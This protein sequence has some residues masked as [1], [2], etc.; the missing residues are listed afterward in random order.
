MFTVHASDS[1]PSFPGTDH[2]H[3]APP[4]G[5]PQSSQAPD[6]TPV[7]QQQL[8]TLARARLRRSGDATFLDTT[9]LVHEACMHLQHAGA[10]GFGDRPD[11]LLQASQLLR[12]VVVGAV[13]SH[14]AQRQ[15]AQTL[16]VT[17]NTQLDESGTTPG[18]EVLRIHEALEALT[19]LD[20][21]L[22]QVVE[23][24]CFG[25]LSDAEIADCLNITERTVQR[26]WQK[27]RLFLAQALK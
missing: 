11:V 13:R 9:A 2:R 12:R 21:R 25:G 4:A 22:G 16:H 8:L 1:L 7:L 19:G 5:S 6:V 10:R 26:D 17:L 18:T 27:A 20:A 3:D 23:L 15:G 24:R 14:E